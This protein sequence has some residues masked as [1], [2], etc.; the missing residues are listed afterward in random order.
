MLPFTLDK[1]QPAS[2]VFAG[3]FYAK[4]PSHTARVGHAGQWLELNWDQSVEQ[5]GI[6]LTYGGWPGPGG[7]HEIALEPTNAAADSLG[8]AIDAGAPPLAPGER[9]D[10]RVT[11]TLTS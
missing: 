5:L 8:E 10:W 2:S 9:R 3:K 4:V 6:W 11:L 7:H 1:V